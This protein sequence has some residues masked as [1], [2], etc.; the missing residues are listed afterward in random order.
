M[1]KRCNYMSFCFVLVMLWLSTGHL[2]AASDVCPYCADLGRGC[3][4]QLQRCI[5]CNGTSG[6]SS[7]QSCNLDTGYCDPKP[8]FQPFVWNDGILIPFMFLSSAIH[9]AAGTGGGTSYIA[10]FVIVLGFR[11]AAASA[12]SHA[13]I[14]AGMIANVLVNL[15][16]RHPFRDMPRIDWNL[17]ATTVPLFLAGSSVGVFLNQTFPNYFLSLFLAAI[18]FLLTV[19]VTWLGV[20]LSWRE[21][22]RHRRCTRSNLATMDA[23]TE[24]TDQAEIN[25][26]AKSLEA[27][28]FDRDEED[29]RVDAKEQS[30]S[31]VAA[32]ELATADDSEQ[33][34]NTSQET[35]SKASAK[36]QTSVDG[37]LQGV[38]L[39]RW[40]DPLLHA[41]TLDEMMQIERSWFQWRYIL[42]LASCWSVLFV[43]RYLSGS[44]DARSPVGM[45]LCGAVFWVVFALQETY[46]VAVALLMYWRNRRLW[47]LRH[48]LDF[49]WYIDAN[50]MG[51]VPFRDVFLAPYM[52]FSLFVGVLDT[53]VGISGSALLVPY[54]YI[55]G[56]VEPFTVQSSI[57]TVIFVTSSAGAVQ[58]LA[59]GQLQISYALFYGL[60]TMLGSFFGVALVYYIARKYHVKAVFLLALAAACAFSF[61]TLVYV[62]I[63]NIAHVAAAQ[64]GWV[65]NN[66]CAVAYKT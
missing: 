34:D 5:P 7:L 2:V 63:R 65:F 3:D 29:V 9:N 55:L 31:I 50:G 42:L 22:A 58:F 46:L 43:A 45:P 62:G 13:F 38:W 33:A 23:A 32:T 44:R 8:L 49:A 61:G 18:M 15:W 60:W 10:L 39:P 54:L 27:A 14:F 57:S 66:I 6:C 1:K 51:D 48:T 28:P 4:A 17:V 36:T 21:L 59:Y 37:A 56:R 25:T 24:R 41:R 64:V 26:T 19:I 20:R 35:F 16:A 47:R 52:L 30:L 11:V 40:L 12:N 53:W